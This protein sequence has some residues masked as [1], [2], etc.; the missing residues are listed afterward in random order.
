ME[1]IKSFMGRKE[2][3]IV[4]PYVGRLQIVETPKFLW[5]IIPGI[6]MEPSAPFDTLSTGYFYICPL[7]ESFT[8]Q[9]RERFHGVV[10][11]RSFRGAIVHEGYPG[12]HLQLPIANPNPSEMRKFQQNNVLVEG[13][14][15]YCEEL[16]V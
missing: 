2:I 11:E 8:A 1:S 16:M 4:L 7:P 9:D 5:G 3:V 10:R 15:L 13:W 14:T 6:A 12:H